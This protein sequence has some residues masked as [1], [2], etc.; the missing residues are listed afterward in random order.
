MNDI[1]RFFAWQSYK[2]IIL[3]FGILNIRTGMASFE[4]EIKT[5]EPV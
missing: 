2:L 1:R 3:D 4:L 5:K